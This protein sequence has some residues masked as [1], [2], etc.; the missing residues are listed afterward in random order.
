MSFEFNFSLEILNHLGRGL[1]RNFATVVAEAV[2]NSWDAEATQ[3]KITLDKEKKEMT[4][5]DN[6]KGMNEK[7]FREKFLRVGYSRRE[8]TDNKSTRK[9]LGRK[10]IGKL[11]MLSISRKVTIISQKKDSKQIG[12]IIDNSKLDQSIEK[13]AHYSLGDLKQKD[14]SFEKNQGTHLKFEGIKETINNPD[15]IKKYL[16]I[17]FN[18]SF[19]NL[20]EEFRMYVNGT[21]VSVKD[22]SQLHENTQF[23]WYLGEKAKENLATFKAF[24]KSKTTYARTKSF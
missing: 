14:L 16:A 4:I 1:Y 20:L 13:D 21:Q 2:S 22:L 3:V 10:G 8:D 17:L 5:E 12:G 19:S 9:I 15:I 7:D 23:I 24:S 11:A 6:G 18:F